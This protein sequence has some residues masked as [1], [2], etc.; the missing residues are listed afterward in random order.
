MPERPPAN[1]YLADEVLLRHEPPVAAV[2]AAIT[3]ISHH[4]VIAGGDHLGAPV[5][6]APKRSVHVI[7]TKRHLVDVYAAADNAH[8]V[9]FLGDHALDEDLVGIERVVERHDVAGARGAELVDEPVDDQP[10]AII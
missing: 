9:A 10:V 3:A 1:L 4:E 8:R 5:L 2:H 7:L 6:V